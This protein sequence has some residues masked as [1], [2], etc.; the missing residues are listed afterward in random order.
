VEFLSDEVHYAWPYLRMHPQYSGEN[1]GEITSDRGSK[2]QEHTNM[3]YA[4]WVDYSNTIDGEAEGLAIF[5]CPDGNTH[6]WLIREYGTFGPRRAEE[7][8]GQPFALKKGG[9][10]S[11]RVGILVHRGN[12][13]TGKVRQR[14]QELIKQKKMK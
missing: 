11:Q 1:G 9:T 13:I 5:Q 14:Y 10:L 12:V 4:L 8:S 3:E 7:K 6:R 2:G